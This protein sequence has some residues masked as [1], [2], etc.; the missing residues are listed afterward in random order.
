MSGDPQLY[1]I[2]R[3]EPLDPEILER[4]RRQISRALLAGP[5][6][7]LTD[8]EMALNHLSDTAQRYPHPEAQEMGR[9]LEELHRAAEAIQQT[10]QDCLFAMPALEIAGQPLKVAL[11][12]VIDGLQRRTGLPIHLEWRGPYRECAPE[13]VL[14]LCR[15]THEA[16]MNVHKH[17]RARQV[18]VQVDFDAEQIHLGI[19]DDGCGFDLHEG[20]QKEKHVGLKS[21]RERA[22]LV[23]G[24]LW[25][26]SQPGRG[27]AVHLTLPLSPAGGSGDRSTRLLSLFRRM[28]PSPV[29]TV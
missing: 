15:I 18:Q 7:D 3:K 1:T 6:Q 17:A 10:I 4:E 5:L 12:Q 22:E 29:S 13:Q 23:G 26:E 27:T 20:L 14:A 28:N 21:M 8:L 19:W 25:V 2:A 16:L 24:K 11:P 9:K